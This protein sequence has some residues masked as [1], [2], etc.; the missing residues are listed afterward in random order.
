MDI[1]YASGLTGIDLFRRPVPGHEFFELGHLL[2][3]DVRENP[4]P[5]GF[6]VDLVHAAGL[7]EGVPQQSRSDGQ[8]T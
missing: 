1:S 2:I 5:P 3:G 6:G 8:E 7:D 4:G